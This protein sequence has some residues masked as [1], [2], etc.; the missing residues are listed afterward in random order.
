MASNTVF[1]TTNGF[2]IHL[3]P[4]QVEIGKKAII[5]YIQLSSIGMYDKTYILDNE[6]YTNWGSDDNYIKNY[7]CQKESYLGQPIP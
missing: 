2:E 4:I 3:F 6:D 1:H 5:K 7:I